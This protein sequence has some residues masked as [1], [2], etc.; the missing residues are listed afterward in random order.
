MSGVQEQG[1]FVL[2]P[3]GEYYT[4]IINKKDMESANGDPLVVVKLLVC[5][6]EYKGIAW[7]WDNIL[8]PPL[9]SPSAKIL[10]RTKHF[11]HCIGEPYEGEEV[12]WNSDN[13]LGKEVKIKIDHEQPNKYHKFI[14]PIV[15]QYILDEDT[16]Q[17]ESPL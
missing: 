4:E 2:L 15:V 3:I 17:E 5:R 7:V 14:K 16:S 13:W 10:G 12:A 6:G 8:I 9:S 11:L 1:E